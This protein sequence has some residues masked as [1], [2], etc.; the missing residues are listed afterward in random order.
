MDMISKIGIAG[1]GQLGKMMILEAKKMGFY[2]T[3]LDPSERCPAHSICDEHIV[4]DFGDEEALRRLASSSDVVTYEFEHINAQALLRLE[5]EGFLIYPS[6]GSLLLIQDKLKQKMTLQSAGIPT[7]AFLPADS[8]Q[9]IEEAA[10]LFGYPLMIKSRFGGYDGKG[11]LILASED[12]IDEALYFSKGKKMAEQWVDF[13][14]EASILACRGA[15][16]R[17]AVY[18]VAENTHIDSILRKT[19]APAEISRELTDEA[20]NIAEKTMHAFQGVGMFCIELFITKSNGILVNE[21]APRPHNSGHYTI[22]ACR[23]SQ[24]ENHIRAVARLP[25]GDPSLVSCAVMANILGE[26]GAC[27][28]ACASGLDRALEVPGASVHIYGKEIS[29]PKRKMGHVTATGATLAEAESR[30]AAASSFLRMTAGAL[31]M[32]D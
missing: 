32:E 14:L 19:R 9:E 25:L 29:K 22:E 3:I 28:P 13:K 21:A 26:D 17:I 31:K 24:F 23:T 10:S 16:G 11:N 20:M 7:P 18:P 4:A 6:A 5:S 1:G 30:A 12:G 2:V 27:G 15:D 8:R